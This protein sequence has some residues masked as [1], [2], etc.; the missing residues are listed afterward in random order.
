MAV[1]TTWILFEA[2]ERTILFEVHIRVPDFW[3]L[4]IGV[5]DGRDCQNGG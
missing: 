3:K 1:S 2:I 4:A 5:I